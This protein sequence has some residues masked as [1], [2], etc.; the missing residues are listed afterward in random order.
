M[1]LS[2]LSVVFNTPNLNVTQVIEMGKAY[3]IKPQTHSIWFC[4]WNLWI[5]LF[6]FGQIDGGSQG[7]IV[8]GT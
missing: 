8:S 1:L 7:A 4:I 2:V 3:R 6:Y 5:L